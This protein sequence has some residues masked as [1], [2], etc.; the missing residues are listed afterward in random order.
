MPDIPVWNKCDN[1]CVMCTNTPAFA[2]QAGEH[3]GLK[4]QIVKLERYLKGLGPVY[5]KNADRSE[6][7]TLTG[8]EPT[9][10]PE[11]FKL[12]AYFR[13]R[14]RGAPITL[15]SNGRRLADRAFAEKFCAVAR[16]PFAVAI[17]L[18][19]PSARI[20]DAVSGVKGSFA[21][22]VSGLKNILS[23]PGA[24]DLEIRL[25]LHR[26]NIS[27]VDKTLAF[28]LKTFPDTGAYRVTAIHYEIEGM[29]LANHRRLAARL[30]DS[31][32]K[33]GEC[34]SLIKS[35]PDFRL[36]H[37]PLCLVRKEL[38]PLC[39]ITLPPED[40]VYPELKCGRCRLRKGCL[41]L[42]AEYGKSF[43]DSELRPVK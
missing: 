26:K 9:L 39:W 17:A 20:H 31:A 21:Q 35:F 5:L 2:G 4:G 6:F 3:Y 19:G 22:T 13:R 7:V 36:Y 28:L 42:M 40:R 25:V 16:P 12:L 18:H 8:G 32:V 27:V 43:G 15:L 33:L 41:G 30:S 38:R 1:K 10:H 23:I 34:L 29:S 11:F 14:L 37:F 24:P